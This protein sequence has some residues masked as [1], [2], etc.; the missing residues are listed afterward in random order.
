[1]NLFSMK[2]YNPRSNDPSVINVKVRIKC[3]ICIATKLFYILQY[4]L[5]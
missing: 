4:Q 1:M 2:I 3:K 5:I